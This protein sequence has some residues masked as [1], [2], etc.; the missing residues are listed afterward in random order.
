M[1]TFDSDENQRLQKILKINCYWHVIHTILIL[2]FC[3][4]LAIIVLQ[5]PF[6]KSLNQQTGSITNSIQTYLSVILPHL[7]QKVDKFE[8]SMIQTANNLNQ[9]LTNINILLPQIQSLLSIPNLNST[10]A[11]VLNQ[12]LLAN[13]TQVA[14]DFHNITVNINTIVSKISN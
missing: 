5:M 14:A 9:V 10:I 4:V 12:F 3:L 11:T 13:V 1:D 7:F 8:D 6:I 2:V